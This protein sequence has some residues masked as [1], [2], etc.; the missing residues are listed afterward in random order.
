[1]PFEFFRAANYFG[2]DS[3]QPEFV[4]THSW[5]HFG[6]RACFEFGWWSRGAYRE[7]VL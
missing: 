6:A 4:R 1:M 2:S 5:V 7:E 3:I